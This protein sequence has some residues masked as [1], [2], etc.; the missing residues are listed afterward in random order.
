MSNFS[1]LNI[2]IIAATFYQDVAEHLQA[3]AVAEL[4]KVGA[5]YDIVTVPGA[6]EIPITLS[7]AIDS[8]LLSYES[9]DGCYHG[10]VALGCVIRGETSH[11]DIVAQES[12]R[13]LLNLATTSQIPLGNGIL[14]VENKDQAIVR[15]DR[16]QGNKG[17]AA[18]QACLS[19]IQHKN[20]FED[21]T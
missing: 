18:V 4:E 14:T 21:W 6:L 11:Y 17:G 15:A 3:G 8:E 16:E 7:M 9:V 10:C 20:R 5:E 13:N 1:D 19:L 12:A 2:L